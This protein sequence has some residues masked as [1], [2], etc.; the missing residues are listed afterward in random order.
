[1]SGICDMFNIAGKKA[2]VIKGVID[3]EPDGDNL[4]CDGAGRQYAK[5]L[6]FSPN[7][8]TNVSPALTMS[9]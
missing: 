6:P 3:A 8:G 1:M 9:R 5:I 4:G 2:I 7:Y